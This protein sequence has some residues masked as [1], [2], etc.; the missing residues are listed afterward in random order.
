MNSHM[1][2][3]MPEL[4]AAPRLRADAW[5]AKDPQHSGRL[6]RPRLPIGQMVGAD[7][8]AVPSGLSAGALRE[9]SLILMVAGKPGRAL[10]V[11]D[12]SCPV[13]EKQQARY[14]HAQSLLI[15]G[16]IAQKLGQPGAE[17]RIRRANR[18]GGDGAGRVHRL[19]TTA[20]AIHTYSREFVMFRGHPGFHHNHMWCVRQ[21]RMSSRGSGTVRFRSGESMT[22]RRPLHF[23]SL[24][25]VGHEAEA[26]LRC[27]YQHHRSLVARHN[28]RPSRSG[29]DLLLRGISSVVAATNS[30]AAAEVLLS[31]QF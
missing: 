27:G 1:I 6:R 19:P 23:N 31:E 15:R 4:A 18:A 9:L 24:E 11:A 20:R 7:H 29:I 16:R 10:R 2:V 22:K 8:T 30:L 3:A 13:A 28:G 17:D 21:R 14:E 26:L 25:D 12:R 5:E